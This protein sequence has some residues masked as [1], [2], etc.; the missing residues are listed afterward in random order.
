MGARQRLNSLYLGG[1]LLLAAVIGG[2]TGSLLLFLLAAGA[3]TLLLI[4]D[5]AI[6]LTP[7]QRPPRS[8]RSGRRRR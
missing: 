2:S 8:P 5:G 3:A 4:Q 1:A 6:R 7:R